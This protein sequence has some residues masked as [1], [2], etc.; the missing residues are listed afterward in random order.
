MSKEQSGKIPKKR[1]RL[2]KERGV[3]GFILVLAL[4]VTATVAV[5]QQPEDRQPKELTLSID[6]AIEMAR[7]NNTHNRMADE[8]IRIV[9]SQY[10][11]TNSLFL[12][13]VT[14]EET[15]ISTN[16]PLNVFGSKL[17]QEVVTAED[18]NPALLND[19][20]DY[21][22]F[23][24]SVNVQ[25]PLL[26]PSGF[27]GR[28]ALKMQLEA[29]RL[30]KERTREYV[31]FQ[32]K[33]AFYQLILTQ[34]RTGIIDTALAAAQ[35]NLDQA[36]DFSK[37]GMLNRADLLAAEVRVKQLKNDRSEARN[38]LENVQR[39]LAY[40]LGL[41]EDAKVKPLGSLEMKQLPQ[42]DVD[43][44]ALNTTRSDMMALEN[45]IE[46]SKKKLASMK[47]NFVP[48]VNLFGSYE[49]N[50]DTLFGTEASNY[51]VGA[52]L[53]WDLF[54]GFKNVASIQ[55]SQA[56]LSKARLQYE[57]KV[58]QNRVEISSAIRSLET[59]REQVDIAESTVAQ[60]QESYRIRSNRFEQGMERMSDL[61]TSESTL[62]Q[63]KLQLASALFNYNVQAAEVE[64]LL[65]RDL[66]N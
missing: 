55:K 36:N 31:D 57:D 33:Q 25:Q 63:S 15:A 40:L 18:F 35:A 28:S 17:R 51:L 64:F 43:F 12:P 52:K 38:M 37:Q 60:A 7:E 9:R 26:N 21:E 30:Q 65:E 23:T 24:T 5:A 42:V 16:N 32:V 49:W 59:A 29:T 8:D 3:T 54:K 27:L 4:L 11:E 41:E 13:Q 34:R 53:Q 66:V 14:L 44:M 45:Q 56:E 19:P 22:N 20:G 39:Q 1:L 61:L 50:D 10:R 6:E 58:L 2:S 62:A 46:A 48:S 47:F